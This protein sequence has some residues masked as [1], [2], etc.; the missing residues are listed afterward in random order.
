MYMVTFWP[1]FKF[2]IV[3]DVFVLKTS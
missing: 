1:D 3:F 2:K